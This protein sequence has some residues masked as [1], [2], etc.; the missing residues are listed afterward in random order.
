M[1]VDAE[2]SLWVA[3]VGG[4]RVV[5]LDPTGAVIGEVPV[6]AKMVTS[7]AFGGPD[8]DELYVV[9]ADNLDEPAK[10]GSIFRCRPGVAGVPTPLVEV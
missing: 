2:G 1:C 8:H 3:H 9:T 5:K 10:G 7:V 4:R 6:P